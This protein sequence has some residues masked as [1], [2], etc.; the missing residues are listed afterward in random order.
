MDIF[1]LTISEE[2]GKSGTDDELTGATMTATTSHIVS[3]S[4]DL[5]GRGIPNLG[6]N[7]RA[8]ACA[9]SDK[10]RRHTQGVPRR[11]KG[12]TLVVAGATPEK[13]LR[14]VGAAQNVE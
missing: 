2:P 7:Q 14:P 13:P 1:E 5:R 9:G 6:R 3:D 8:N 10:G 11:G 12:V 4:Y